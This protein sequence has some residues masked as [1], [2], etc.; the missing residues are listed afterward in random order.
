M[1]P[2]PYIL[3]EA[4]FSQLK[5]YAPNVAI[6]PWGATEAHNY[7]LPHGTDVIEATVLAE[8]A[9]RI[10]DEAGAKVIVLP[11]IPFGNN[12]QQQD[13]CATIHFGTATAAAILLDVCRSLKRQGIDRLLL[14]NSHG[15]NDFKPLIRDAQLETGML[16]VLANFFQ[17]VPA[18]EKRIFPNP[19]DHA[20]Q[21]ETSFLLH[22]CPDLVQTDLAGPGKRIAFE[23]TELAQPGVWTPRPWSASHPDTGSG[24]PAGATAEMGAEYCEAVTNAISRVL[25]ALS[26]AK[27]GQSPYSR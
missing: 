21:L 6:L 12:A 19:G 26:A 7:H 8:R 5:K 25:I 15:G 10:A 3:M 17:M 24:D 11:T 4:S 13:Q 27:K 20:G 2:R 16:I 1:P 9:A 23:V 18:D 14:L 22:V